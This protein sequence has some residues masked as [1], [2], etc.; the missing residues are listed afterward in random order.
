MNNSFGRPYV[1]PFT[2]ANIV[3]AAAIIFFFM[4]V[5]LFGNIVTI[6]VISTNSKL[7]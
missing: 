2:D 3:V 4:A 7:K 1:R 5:G 6:I